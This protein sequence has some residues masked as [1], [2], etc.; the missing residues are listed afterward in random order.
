MSM[1]S[2]TLYLLT[3]AVC[4]GSACQTILQHARGS[5]NCLLRLQIAPGGL[6]FRLMQTTGEVACNWMKLSAKL[7]NTCLGFFFFTALKIML[8]PQYYTKLWTSWNC[9][10]SE[11]W[12]FMGTIRIYSSPFMDS[13]S[14]A[15]STV[16]SYFFRANFSPALSQCEII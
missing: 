11:S 14:T 7:Q 1:T 5:C 10:L 12:P 15:F 2:V 13:L 6:T 9:I 16:I 3:V 8:Y 4:V